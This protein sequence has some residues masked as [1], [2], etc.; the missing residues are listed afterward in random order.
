MILSSKFWNIS[1][2][3]YHCNFHAPYVEAYIRFGILVGIVLSSYFLEFV[4]SKLIMKDSI[5]D[6]Y[7][8][9]FNVSVIAGDAA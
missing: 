7:Q 1:S 5:S 8:Q 3:K 2:K 4:I 9:A 6:L